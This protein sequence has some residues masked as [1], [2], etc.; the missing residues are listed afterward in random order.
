MK[1]RR[2]RQDKY[3]GTRAL[4]KVGFGCVIASMANKDAVMAQEN[5]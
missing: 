4:G 3:A 1:L 5:A 2:M